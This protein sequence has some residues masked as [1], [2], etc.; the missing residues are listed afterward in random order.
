MNVSVVNNAVGVQAGRAWLIW[1][2]AS[3]FV[4]LQFFI[5]L[6]TGVILA[7]MMQA[8]QLT[9][10]GA[11]LLASTYYY[12]YMG[13]QVPAGLLLDRYGSRLVLSVGAMVFAIGTLFFT[14]GHT[15]PVAAV[16]RVMM[17]GGAA[18][19]FIGTLGLIRQHFPLR[20]FAFMAGLME[21][22]GMFGI[23]FGSILLAYA[24]NHWGWQY[25]VLLVA[26]LAIVV[27]FLLWLVVPT[28]HASHQQQSARLSLWSSL[29]LVFGQPRAW[30]N[31][32]YC[33][34]LF[35]VVTVFAALW[36]VPFLQQAYSLSLPWAT[37]LTSLIY[38][39]VAIGCPLSGWLA[40]RYGHVRRLMMLSAVI[41][42]ALLAMIIGVSLPVWLLVIV[43][44]VLGIC[45]CAYMLCFSI[46][47]HLVD[48]AAHNTCAG[49][50]NML[51]VLLAPLFQPLI[52][53][54]VT[55][56]AEQRGGALTYLT[57]DYQ[58]GLLI[59]PIAL[60]VAVVLAYFLPDSVVAAEEVHPPKQELYSLN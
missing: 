5:Q 18:F 1:A 48:E 29:K 44:V 39:G 56:S 8:F 16:G 9:A 4:L 26:P 13:L 37:K 42:A 11:S 23:L 60:G 19:A 7:D 3:S 53:A 22:L 59:M 36:C 28:H 47:N 51:S 35:S 43:L 6:S 45:C 27:S 10:F 32:I 2:V 17:G 38:V 58:K 50:T 49:F 52:G 54:I 24:V 57:T 46:A 41:S 31:G 55:W 25:A 15:W 20:Q 21:M 33:S 40:G 14:L 12:I 34:I 30:V